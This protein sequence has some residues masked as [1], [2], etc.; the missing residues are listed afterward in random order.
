M[1]GKEALQAPK[2]QEKEIIFFLKKKNSLL[3]FFFP[4]GLQIVEL[5]AVV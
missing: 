1:S 3:F 4:T 5:S 2:K